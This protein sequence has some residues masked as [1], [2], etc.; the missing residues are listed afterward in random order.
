[1]DKIRDVS[2][3]K[4]LLDKAD[5]IAK[6][7]QPYNSQLSVMFRQCFLNTIQTTVKQLPDNSYFVITGDIPA[8][9]LRDSTAQIRPYIAFASQ[10][11]QLDSII[12]GIIDK[13]LDCTLIDCYANAFNYE[14]KGFA[15]RD[16]TWEHPMVWERKYEVDSLCNVIELMYSYYKETGNTRIFTQKSLL[17]MKNIYNL[18]RLEQDHKNSN[19]TFVRESA[20]VPYDTLSNN[21]FGNMIGYTG[22]T[23]SGFRPSDDACT[24]NYLIP[25]NMMAVVALKHAKEILIY[26]YKDNDLANDFEKLADEIQNGIEVFG[27]IHHEKYKEIY[28]YEVD[29]LGNHLLMDDANSP[30]LLST[31]YF[32]YCSINDPIYQNT[33]RFILSHDNPYYY[34]GKYAS[35]IGSPH[36]PQGYIWH[37]ALIMQ[38]LTSNSENEIKMCL[39]MIL[40]TDADTG[41]MHESFSP[42]NPKDYTRSWFAWANTL[43][44]ELILKLYNQH[45]F[46]L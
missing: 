24:Y 39:D 14:P 25:S 27:I 8:M 2:I 20:S 15:Y 11:R 34:T 12:T 41:F 16:R 37:I 5:E 10:D 19:Y 45:F 44:A 38:A 23:W 17:C 36:T 26:V 9:W 6:A 13:Q 18:F 40:A 7:L 30:S 42:N 43:F 29:G 35:G 4:I 3:P 32:G 28:A 21:G 46:K 22:L 33:R 31:P 1:M